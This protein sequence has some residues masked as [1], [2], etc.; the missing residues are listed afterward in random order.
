M[1]KQNVKNEGDERLES[2]ET[3][4][5]K[6]EQFVIDN[7][8]PIYIVLAVLII[9]VLAFFGVKKYYLEPREKDAQAAIYHAEQYFENDNFATALNG[10]GN[11]L[12]FVD[13][14]NDFG[15][16]KTANLAKY[17]AGVCCLNTG[18]FNKAV[19]YLKSYKGKDVLVSSLAL[20]CL[21]DAYMELGNVAEA[22]KCYVSAAKKSANSFTSPM[23]L[24]RA[25]MAY[26]MVGDYQNAINVYNTIKADYPNSNEGFSIEKYIARAQAEMK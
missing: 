5:T 7:Q 23:Y 2:I 9:A 25:G 19:E 12:G 8:K 1:A 24:L 22:A 13:V 15:G 18:D 16:T 20:G 26:E 6:A 10:D 21:A 17:Y 4:L 3:T 11:Y 14:I